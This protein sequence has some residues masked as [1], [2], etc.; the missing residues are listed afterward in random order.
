M[1]SL[2]KLA[3]TAALAL[4]ALALAPA[5][6]AGDVKMIAQVAA[7]ELAADGTSALVTVKNVKGGAE[8]K[9]TVKDAATLDKLAAK[10][11]A[12]GDQVRLSYDDSGGANL[13]K[14]FKKAEGC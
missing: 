8:V 1:H 12:P 13:T 4:A 14:T 11:I 7:V 2:N 10:S 5:A 9:L 3:A 6:S